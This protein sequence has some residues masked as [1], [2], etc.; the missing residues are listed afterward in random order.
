MLYVLAELQAA[1][2]S[3]MSRSCVCWFAWNMFFF[4]S[5]LKNRNTLLLLAF[6]RDRNHTYAKR[7][8]RKKNDWT[9]NAY[10]IASSCFSLTSIYWIDSR[11]VY[12]VDQLFEC[13]IN[14]IWN[15]MSMHSIFLVLVTA[16][17]ISHINSITK[18]CIQIH[19]FINNVHFNQWSILCMCSSS[20]LNQSL[21]LLSIT[22]KTMKNPIPQKIDTKT[23]FSQK[24]YE[25]QRD[26][27]AFLIIFSIE[28]KT[29]KRI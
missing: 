28:L 12:F 8:N 10:G 11:V 24:I 4:F 9:H 6:R 13:V 16:D 19:S 3:F 25:W 18:K 5:L 1:M 27:M 15:L 21:N 20:N 14:I 7:K 17:M 22:T 26:R 29:S 2:V 23:L